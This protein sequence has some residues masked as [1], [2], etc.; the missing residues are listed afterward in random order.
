MKD[1][2]EFRNWWAEYLRMGASP[3]AAVALSKMNAEIDVRNV[4]PSVR[5]PTLV[6]H[7]RGDACLAF[8]EGR[9]VASLIPESE[10]V[11]FEGED[12]LPFI[13]NQ[14]EVIQTIER[15]VTGLD[16]SGEPDRVLATVMNVKILDPHDEARRRGEEDWRDLFE[17][18]RDYVARKV[19]NFKGRL[20]S[21]DEDGVLAV[22]DGP[23][24]AIRCASAIT[25]NASKLDVQVK[26][27][28]HTGECDLAGGQYSGFA[29]DLAKKIAAEPSPGTV[30]VSRTVKDLVA[31][32]GLRFE[33][34]GTRSFGNGDWRLF[35]VEP[36]DLP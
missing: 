20:I 21:Y 3:G 17:R 12:H 6:M 27:G 23:A 32:S 16:S 5:V 14:D 15:F 34:F 25:G 9:Y 26:A 4:L 24:R 11:E 1:D 13:G 19:E 36:G 28:V 31:G 10:F 2:E 35:T 29:V 8:E 18:S 30:L 22:F 7:R 33:E